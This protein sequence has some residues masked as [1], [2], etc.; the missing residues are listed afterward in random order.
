MTRI[1][2]ERALSSIPFSSFRPNNNNEPPHERP[3]NTSRICYL[4]SELVRT[5]PSKNH[6]NDTIIKVLG[7]D[8]QEHQHPKTTTI[9]KKL[10]ASSSS[11]VFDDGGRTEQQQEIDN[12]EQHLID[13]ERF[14]HHLQEPHSN[15]CLFRQEHPREFILPQVRASLFGTEDSLQQEDFSSSTTT[16]NHISNLFNHHHHSNSSNINNNKIMTRKRMNLISAISSSNSEKKI[17][18]KRNLTFSQQILSHLASW[19]H[20]FVILSMMLCVSNVVGIVSLSS[21][22][23]SISSSNNHNDHVNV[24]NTSKHSLVSQH[25]HSNF[26][27]LESYS[28]HS[29]QFWNTASI[30]VDTAVNHDATTLA[31]TTTQNYINLF[32][33]EYNHSSSTSTTNSYEYPHHWLLQSLY[34]HFKDFAESATLSN[35]GTTNRF[36]LF[37]NAAQTRTLKSA[38]E[39][40]SLSLPPS[41]F[42]LLYSESSLYRPFI[43]HNDTDLTSIFMKNIPYFEHNNLTLY[44]LPISDAFKNFTKENSDLLSEMFSTAQ[45]LLSSS[46]QILNGTTSN[47]LNFILHDPVLV[48]NQ[49]EL[50]PTALKSGTSTYS[51]NDGMHLFGAVSSDGQQILIL[52]VL[53]QYKTGLFSRYEKW[54]GIEDFCSYNNM[55]L[56]SLESSSFFELR[57]NGINTKKWLQSIRSLSVPLPFLI[58]DGITNTFNISENFSVSASSIRDFKFC[59][60][61]GTDNDYHFLGAI[62]FDNGQL[63]TWLDD[64]REGMKLSGNGASTFIQIES[65]YRRI[66]ALEQN[67]TLFR[68]ED[69]LIAGNSSLLSQYH[70][71]PENKGSESLHIVSFVIDKAYSNDTSNDI[72]SI[73]LLATNRNIDYI[74]M[75]G[76]NHYCQINVAFCLGNDSDYQV[77]DTYSLTYSPLVDWKRVTNIFYNSGGSVV[78]LNSGTLIV[79]GNNKNAKLGISSVSIVPYPVPV[80][81]NF[82]TASESVW[83]YYIFDSFSLYL[84]NQKRIFMV[85]KFG[86]GSENY[87]MNVYNTTFNLQMHTQLASTNIYQEIMPEFKYLDDL[88]EIVQI[89]QLIQTQIGTSTVYVP[90]VLLFI[91]VSTLRIQSFITSG[92]LTNFN[93]YEKNFGTG[94]YNSEC[95][96]LPLNIAFNFTS[97]SE[98]GD[99]RGSGFQRGPM[100]A[101][102]YLV[103]DQTWKIW[104]P[105]QNLVNTLE[106]SQFG[107]LN[108]VSLSDTYSLTSL[109]HDNQ[110]LVFSVEGQQSFY[111]ETATNKY[112]IV[113]LPDGGDIVSFDLFSG[114]SF[115]EINN[116]DANCA[117]SSFGN[118][119]CWGGFLRRMM[120]ANFNPTLEGN[121][122]YTVIYTNVSLV[123]FNIPCNL[124]SVS[125]GHIS[126]LGKDSR[127]YNI[128]ISIFKASTLLRGSRSNL[129]TPFVFYGAEDSQQDSTFELFVNTATLSTSSVC[130]KIVSLMS[131]TFCLGTDNKLY[132]QLLLPAIVANS[133]VSIGNYFTACPSDTQF[134]SNVTIT[135]AAFNSSVLVSFPKTEQ[136]SV[137]DIEGDDFT[138]LIL[139]ST[140]RLLKF[141]YFGPF[142]PFLKYHSLCSTD[143]LDSISST[144]SSV[145]T[146]NR[147]VV[148]M[149]CSRGDAL[150]TIDSSKCA[151]GYFGNDCSI[152]GSCTDAQNKG[153]YCADSQFV[154]LPNG[155]KVPKTEKSSYCWFGK[156]LC[157]KGFTGNNCDIP[158]C[159]NLTSFDSE[160]VACGG[161]ERGICVAPDTCQCRNG[162]FSGR[163]CEVS[164]P[165]SATMIIGDSSITTDGKYMTQSGSII[166]SA[167]SQICS[168][169]LVISTNL[170]VQMTS[171]FSFTFD[172]SSYSNG[173]S[174]PILR[175]KNSTLVVPSSLLSTKHNYNISLS[176]SNLMNNASTTVYFL[177]ENLDCSMFGIYCFR[178]DDCG[179][180]QGTVGGKCNTSTGVCTCY[181]NYFGPT[182]S[183]P[184]SFFE[185][186]I[187]LS[188]DSKFSTDHPATA[189]LF[190]DSDQITLDA[191]KT[192]FSPS[193]Y[194]S[195][196][197]Y[198]WRTT[199]NTSKNVTLWNKL[200]YNKITHN[201]QESLVWIVNGTDLLPTVN[202]G[203]EFVVQTFLPETRKRSSFNTHEQSS[204]KMVLE[205]SQAVQVS[206]NATKSLVAQIDGGLT[207]EYLPLYAVRNSL[208]SQ[209]FVNSFENIYIPSVQSDGTIKLSSTSF[210][211]EDLPLLGEFYERYNWSCYRIYGHDYNAL[212][213][214]QV[215]T[216]IAS[217]LL[218]PCSLTPNVA[219]SKSSLR[220]PTNLLDYYSTY[221]I[222]LDYSINTRTS[223]TFKMLRT[224]K[225]NENWSVRVYPTIEGPFLDP[226]KSTVLSGEIVPGGIFLSGITNLTWEWTVSYWGKEN[227]QLSSPILFKR[228]TSSVL[229]IEPKALFAYENNQS[230]ASIYEFK[231]RAKINNQYWTSAS[232]TRKVASMQSRALLSVERVKISPV[233]QGMNRPLLDQ[234]SI[235]IPSFDISISGNMKYEVYYSI[236]G[237][238]SDST[239]RLLASKTRS[240]EIVTF[241]PVSHTSALDIHVFAILYDEGS[242]SENFYYWISSEQVNLAL[243]STVIV[244]N[245]LTN[246]LA[247]LN[248]ISSMLDNIQQ[249]MTDILPNIELIL[250]RNG[251]Q[252]FDPSMLTDLFLTL[253][254]LCESL[255]ELGKAYEMTSAAFTTMEPDIR[256]KILQVALSTKQKLLQISIMS[257]DSKTRSKAYLLQLINS[258][259]KQSSSL[260]LDSISE[261]VAQLLQPLL[262]NT[263]KTMNK[264][265]TSKINIVDKRLV[266]NTGSFS[267]KLPSIS[268]TFLSVLD[269]LLSTPS[270]NSHIIMPN[271]DQT[272]SSFCQK[273][274]HLLSLRLVEESEP[275][276]TFSLINKNVEIAYRRDLLNLLLGSDVKHDNS[277]DV[278]YVND[279]REWKVNGDLLVVQLPDEIKQQSL[280]ISDIDVDAET[281]TQRQSRKLTLASTQSTVTSFDVTSPLPLN[282]SDQFVGF[283][284]VTF[285]NLD[286]NNSQTLLG[287]AMISVEFLYNQ[288]PLKLRELKSPIEMV[289]FADPSIYLPYYLWLGG[290][291]HYWNETTEQ[292][293]KEGCTTVASYAMFGNSKPNGNLISSDL[294][295]TFNRIY[296]SCN[297]TTLFAVLKTND[298]NISLV[299]NF[300]NKIWGDLT[301]N[302][303]IIFF[304]IFQIV[305]MLMIKTKHNI[306]LKFRGLIP[307]YGTGVLLL[308][309]IFTL[310]RDGLIMNIFLTGVQI[311]YMDTIDGTLRTIV[312]PLFST[313]IFAYTLSIWQYYH[314]ERFQYLMKKYQEKDEKYSIRRYV[315]FTSRSYLVMPCFI[316]YAAQLVTYTILL[317]LASVSILNFKLVFSVFSLIRGGIIAASVLAAFFLMIF[318]ELIMKK[319]LNFN[320]VKNDGFLKFEGTFNG[321]VYLF[322]LEWLAYMFMASLLVLAEGYDI[323]NILAPNLYSNTFPEGSV[324][325]QLYSRQAHIHMLEIAPIIL[326]FMIKCL[327][328]L[329]Y[330]GFV[331]CMTAR[332]HTLCCFAGSQTDTTSDSELLDVVNDPVLG[333]L[334]E[335]YC[336]KEFSLPLV[337]LYKQLVDIC[338]FDGPHSMFERSQHVRKIYK[339]FLKK[340]SPFP[341]P[342]NRKTMRMFHIR[343][344]QD[345]AITAQELEDLIS[346]LQVE[347]TDALMSIYWRFKKTE[348]YKKNE[349]KSVVNPYLNEDL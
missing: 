139:T 260:S 274:I 239:L 180:G 82:P 283:K 40:P 75:K 241:L 105:A 313:M 48:S 172:I 187:S 33:H 30:S 64:F 348:A 116:S 27:L 125:T 83:K 1:I 23:L 56:T 246:G 332:K 5:C 10:F 106:L 173:I 290:G 240:N 334:F 280:F 346:I 107:D 234:F 302:S 218:A 138:L 295:P 78:T 28:H 156:C 328:L 121:P 248:T 233:V 291:C 193:K 146:G 111:L 273:W 255:N 175:L 307:F 145:F 169:Q 215:R 230:G 65:S 34:L 71:V 224:L 210:D 212:S 294:N 316:I 53:E 123:R 324:A 166:D 209:V 20:A 25:Y 208:Q 136:Y 266:S 186:N 226:F 131:S 310:V 102:S 341:V 297:H 158:I 6:P 222:V 112:Q 259:V 277:M 312:D 3:T 265:I 41:S 221:V 153:L 74:Y 268:E 38:L 52:P 236:V 104:G 109:K 292:W 191:S 284:I 87:D 93:V 164:V 54:L 213:V 91:G 36:I 89:P 157:K 336:M 227:S 181:E 8:I 162:L 223:S 194:G 59:I 340:Y 289:F 286:A 250:E 18:K 304:C 155:A 130:K 171:N 206:K 147:K 103:K 94:Y 144:F 184:A 85:A 11:E 9:I 143:L 137:V 35:F 343:K 176:V 347:T 339:R 168:M 298:S 288:Q 60:Y 261:L 154:S 238:S 311:P 160:H 267:N 70:M 337:Y 258:L 342:I 211:P 197:K 235:S 225:Q 19:I 253:D 148:S 47:T 7:T 31:L 195:F 127:V 167:I 185:P 118:L 320:D 189:L 119:F 68:I 151:D 92:A 345:E 73:M 113:G 108:T 39:E 97:I 200:I 232:F 90:S 15:N 293:S 205:R 117:L 69:N 269:S 101:S 278:D 216:D 349:K 133:S 122:L 264:F 262:V 22:V 237:D 45:N 63:L 96:S 333:P 251:R 14:Y 335:S 149:K 296:C 13:S 159:Y 177:L 150:F 37:V 229:F 140:D 32:M 257:K 201:T 80:D 214:K 270:A 231:V 16:S 204:Y 61:K 79:W 344:D 188:F 126:I 303:L 115:K 57:T 338:A 331:S 66:Y 152:E 29:H 276:E 309:A 58:F 315:K 134:Y 174:T 86:N 183:T 207:E 199:V 287:N 323:L 322:K 2:I 24:N 178:D 319:L 254:K 50:R 275:S 43:D 326:L 77:V 55:K 299:Q 26:I 243:N 129:L 132:Y 67:G 329:V 198:F 110:T 170:S 282:I 219:L 46:S 281:T 142:D 300:T 317:V 306:A 21:T 308:E 120:N 76:N 321:D 88:N 4:S 179:L 141:S 17:F 217:N 72:D 128:G 305:F 124:F 161:L 263:M 51:G 247:Y 252:Y 271:E 327:V 330:G 12:D 249:N 318:V 279:T 285:K 301:S 220:I 135:S 98:I 42:E 203:I 49:R 182:C 228:S 99:I 84:T 44:N 100:F 81:F 242:E 245:T 196:Q 202:Y 190:K 272:L 95:G 165:P 244:N 62:L 114:Y 192:I 256:K 325:F 163:E 314:K